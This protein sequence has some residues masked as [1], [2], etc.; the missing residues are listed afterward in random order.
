VAALGLLET[1][2][3]SVTVSRKSPGQ[4][5]AQELAKTKALLEKRHTPTRTKASAEQE[6]AR[7]AD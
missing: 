1:I 6:A 2:E 7:Q 3:I 5:L 4:Q